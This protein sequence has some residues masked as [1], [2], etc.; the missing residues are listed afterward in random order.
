MWARS[1]ATSAR[2][3]V[4]FG[5]LTIV[6]SSQ[7]GASSGTRFWKNDEPP[8]PWGKRCISV[9]RPPIARSNGASTDS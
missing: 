4:P 3:V 9:G 6:V 2:D 1:A 8:A 7:S 5:V